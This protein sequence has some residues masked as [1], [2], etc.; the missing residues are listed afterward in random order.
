M[1]VGTLKYCN[2]KFQFVASAPERSKDQFT[3]IY[4]S[5]IHNYME[6]SSDN[7]RLHY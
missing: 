4:L 6:Y 1:F 7:N 2:N 5:K 3:I